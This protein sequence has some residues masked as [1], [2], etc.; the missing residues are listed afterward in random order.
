MTGWAS[1]NFLFFVA[2]FALHAVGELAPT[3]RS[4]W[5]TAAQ[6]SPRGS[7]WAPHKFWFES[8]QNW[9]SEF[10][11][12]APIMGLSVYLRK[13]GSAEFKPVAEPHYETG[14]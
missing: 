12:V 5:R 2:S 7:I 6:P 8:F 4:S 13:R 1:D 10:L 9:Q 3:A 14:A 11:A